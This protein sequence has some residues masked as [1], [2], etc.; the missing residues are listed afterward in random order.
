MRKKEILHLYFESEKKKVKVTESRKVTLRGW[1][2]GQMGGRWLKRYKLSAI[3]A[4][5]SDDLM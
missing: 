4:L 5:R 1:G 3:R 2:V